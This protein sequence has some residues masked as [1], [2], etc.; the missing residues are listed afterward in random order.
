M[1]GIGFILA[2]VTVRSFKHKGGDGTPAPWDPI[3]NFIIEGPYQ[4]VRNPM[5]IGVLLILSGMSLLTES[6]LIFFWMVLFF[7]GYNV[8]T[9]VKE[10]P[11]LADRFGSSY[12]KYKAEV[13]RWLPRRTPYRP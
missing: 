8:Y 5:L 12:L 11:Q 9:I 7:I 1:T 10:E 6:W 4:Y 13:P 3:K 2:I